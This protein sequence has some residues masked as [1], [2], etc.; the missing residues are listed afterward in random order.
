M[1]NKRRQA[2]FI[3]VLS[4]VG[5]IVVGL[6]NW[7]LSGTIKCQQQ[8]NL[9]GTFDHCYHVYLDVGSNVGIQIRKLY[10]PHLFTDPIPP[11]EECFTRMFGSPEERNMKE[12]CTFGFEPNPA[13]KE[14]L[15]VYQL[16]LSAIRLN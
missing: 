7:L 3:I 14:G 5:I 10:E 13:H 8:E 4:C 1:L 6:T 9:N 15:M 11:V 16:V 12:I 2:T